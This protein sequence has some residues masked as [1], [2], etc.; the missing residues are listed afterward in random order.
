MQ[1]LWIDTDIGD[2][3]DDVVALLFAVR[4]PELRLVGVSTVFGLVER[5]TWL[6]RE[7]L[8]RAGCEA[9]VLSGAVLPLKGRTPGMEP[10]SYLTV[11]PSLPVAQPENDEARLDAIAET[12]LALSEPFHFVTIG[13]MTNAAKL[14]QRHPALPD[15]WLSVICMAGELEGRA[16][17]NVACDVEG[18]RLVV[19]H[20]HPRLVGLEACSNTLPRAE[21]E[22]LLDPSDPAS[23]FLLECYAGYRRAGWHGNRDQAPLTLFDPISVLSLVQPEALNLQRLRVLV[24][25]EGT[26]RLTDDGAE[27]EYA[28][29]NEWAR[30]EPTVR[31]LLSGK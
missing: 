20:L 4:H 23:A 7:T 8:R 5:R 15:R 6:A 19:K 29:S 10:S 2:D 22:S 21:V 9:P 17:Y 3:I 24:E 26:L 31:R 12:M 28:L 18:A 25:G 1:P 27:V 13:A 11:A 30:L 14:L 16:E